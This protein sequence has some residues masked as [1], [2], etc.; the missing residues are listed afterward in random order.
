METRHE[1]ELW[2]TATLNSVEDAVFVTNR[3]GALSYMNPRAVALSGWTEEDAFNQPI[4]NII[5]FSIDDNVQTVFSSS[6]YVPSST[7][8]QF[9]GLISLIQRDEEKHPVTGSAIPVR[10]ETGATIA[11]V[12]LLRDATIEHHLV[13]AK[14]HFLSIVAHQLRTPLGS[15]RWCMDMLLAG[16]L[17]EIPDEAQREITKLH[18]SNQQMI[19]LVNDLLDLARNRN[20]NNEEPS[21][22]LDIRPV[23]DNI[24]SFLEL[25]AQR[26]RVLLETRHDPN[27]SPI[28]APRRRF[29]EVIRNLVSNA[30]KYSRPGGH[31]LVRT[32][33]HD[34]F[35]RIEV[36]D[37][38]IGIPKDE[39]PNIFSKFFRASNAAH[40]E[41]EGSG[42]G[43]AV[44]KYF[45]ERWGGTVSFESAE[46]QGTTFII[47]IPF[48]SSENQEQTNRL[49]PTTKQN[50]NDESSIKK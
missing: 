46:N 15:A 16:D 45:V 2:I 24:F 5:R 38:G 25:D 37:E 26:K 36:S 42:L 47:E 50:T 41:P 40:A 11:T 43:L 4:G 23:I 48:P 21:I 17:G 39:Q 19:E 9:T 12:I 18:A 35:C 20:A 34:Q 33:S 6:P 49:Q 3:H 10:D 7:P 30:I 22:H 32:L 29:Y 31:V 8:Q 14:D 44:V 13:Q 1:R 28:F 27:L